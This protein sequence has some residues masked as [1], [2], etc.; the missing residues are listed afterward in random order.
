MIYSEPLDFH[1][2][3]GVQRVHTLSKIPSSPSILALEL[4]RRGWNEEWRL[5]LSGCRSSFPVVIAVSMS[6]TYDSTVKEGLV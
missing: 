6:S 1:N 5:L 2:I 3:L 4:L